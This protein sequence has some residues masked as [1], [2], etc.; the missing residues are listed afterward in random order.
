MTFNWSPIIL[1]CQLSVENPSPLGIDAGHVRIERSKSLELIVTARGSVPLPDLSKHARPGT[2]W[3]GKTLEL[4]WTDGSRPCKAEGFRISRSAVSQMEEHEPTT[5]RG[6]ASKLSVAFGSG[7]TEV[8]TTWLCNMPAR[9]WPHTTTWKTGP[10]ATTRTRAG[11]DWSLQREGR[12]V[13][14]VDHIWFDIKHPLVSRVVIGEVHSSNLATDEHIAS[15]GFMEL[16]RGTEGLPHTDLRRTFLRALEFLLGAGLGVIGTSEFDTDGRCLYASAD[17]GYVPGGQSEALPPALLHERHIDA[18]SPDLVSSFVQRFIENE[19]H[20]GLN[21]AV[22]LFLNA[23]NAPL[24]M[25]AGYVGAAFEILVRGY[26]K[27]PSNES[28]SKLLAKP[29]WRT[30]ESTLRKTL[31]A[32]AD[33]ELADD[34]ASIKAVQSQLGQLNRVSG[35]KLNALFL[36]DLRLQHGEVEADAL[37]ARNDAAHANAMEGDSFVRVLRSYRALHTL[38]ARAMFAVLQVPVRYFDYTAL[39]HPPRGLGEPQAGTAL[40][41]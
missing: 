10:K 17:S 9:T 14:A 1:P 16:W 30:V 22:W 7:T 27:L 13:S 8:H 12:L 15:P 3:S 18:L 4:S 21:R 25:A 40:R 23:R 5:V 26:Y 39:D 38:F 35:K 34:E 6:R 37:Q 24:D 11:R 31:D 20:Y 33:G 36:D 32:L 29:K 28:R 2:V 41:D 19:E